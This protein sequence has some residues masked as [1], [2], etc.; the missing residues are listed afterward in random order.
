MS[1]SCPAGFPIGS[2]ERA[3][4]GR[5]CSS[6]ASALYFSLVCRLPSPSVLNCGDEVHDKLIQHVAFDI[7]RFSVY[8]YL[9][10]LRSF[11]SSALD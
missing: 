5:Y 11:L 9:V 7:Q 8:W 4:Y 1:R 3:E 2:I 10:C 6:T